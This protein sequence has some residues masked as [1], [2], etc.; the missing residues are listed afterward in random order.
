VEASEELLQVM[1]AEAAHLCGD[2]CGGR[3]SLG[4]FRKIFTALLPGG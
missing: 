2:E 1:F 3:I 4:H